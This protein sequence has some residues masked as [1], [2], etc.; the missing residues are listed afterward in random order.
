MVPK[1][2]PLHQLTAILRTLLSER[3]PI[4]DLRQ[5]LEN[6]AELS[7]RKLSIADTAEALRPGLASLQIQQIAPL[8]SPLPVITLSADME[9]MMISMVRQNGEG[10]LILENNFATRLLTNIAEVNDEMTAQNKQAVMVVSPAI[11]RP[12]AGIIRQH[13][14]DIIVL[15]FNELPDTRKVDVVATINGETDQ[16]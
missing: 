10:E 15:S 13:I 6:L 14:D 1:L 12:L 4:S 16:S 5:I 2:V 3:M 8:N 9:Q 7:T 11:R